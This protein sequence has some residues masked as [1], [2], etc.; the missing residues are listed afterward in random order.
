MGGDEWK[1]RASRTEIENLTT[2]MKFKL[3]GSTGKQTNCP[4]CFEDYQKD[5][6]VR[7]LKCGHQYHPKCIDLWLMECKMVCP[8]CQ[9]RIDNDPKIS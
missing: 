6:T 4:I 5:E 3:S 9:R 7:V 8:L 1:Q 2:I